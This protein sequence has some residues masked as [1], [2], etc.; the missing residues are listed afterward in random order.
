M[1]ERDEPYRDEP[2]PTAGGR[3]AERG[4]VRHDPDDWRDST[5]PGMTPVPAPYS[6]AGATAGYGAAAPVTGGTTA[7]DYSSRPLAVRRPDALAA[8]LLVLAGV[9]AGVSLLLRWLDGNATTGWDLLRLAWHQ[10]HS[11]VGDFFRSGMWQPVAVVLAGVVLFVL[12][13]LL[14]VPARTHRTLGVLALLASL[15]AAAGVLVPLSTSGWRFSAFDLGF[16]FACAVAV[17]GLLGALKALLSRQRAASE[18][19][20]RY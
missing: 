8:L 4:T 2:Y 10:R 11:G 15:G 19:A 20:P 16:W 7:P 14:L 3:P 18:P 9:A 1:S 6:G 17:L 13:L 12:G 5:T